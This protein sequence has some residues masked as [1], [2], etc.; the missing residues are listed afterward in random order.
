MARSTSN[1]L[2]VAG[3]LAL[4]A[5]SGPGRE[6]A[7]RV[8]IDADWAQVP[9][10]TAYGELSAV[11]VDSHGHI[12][13]LHRAGRE[14]VEPF[15]TDPIAEPTVFMFA[16]NGKLLGK[17]GAGTLVMPHGLSV[18]DEDKVWITDVAREQVLR[19]SHDGAEE[20]A[21]GERGVT[22]QDDG[23]FGRPAD[24]A[25]LPGKVL[26]ADGYLNNR[27]ALFDREGDFLEHWGEEGSAA[28]EFDLPHSV[29]SDA[30]RV[31]VADRENG[32]VQ[33]LTHAG[34]P[35]AI[36]KPRGTGHPYAAK[37]IGGGYVLVI[38]G[39]DGAGRYG[40]IGRLYREDGSLDRIFDAGV[41]PRTGTSLGH[42]IA[43]A[44]DGSVYMVD[45][46][47]NRVVK[48]ELASAGLENS[49]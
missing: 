6:V 15:P 36:W 10:G 47:A 46:K 38:E 48:F 11:D 32:R 41:D 14:W 17:W 18:D 3:A 22:G 37:P 23:H 35:V 21:L 42:D 13:V 44:R 39:R 5:C 8:E 43:V 28:G 16:A 49:E 1:I 4:A 34:E 27:I 30:N 45:N 33:V 24:V 25:F 7:P 26:V 12:F 31:Y 40:A 29:E 9:E 20:L 19:F 2:A